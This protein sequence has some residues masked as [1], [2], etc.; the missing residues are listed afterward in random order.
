MY[1]NRVQAHIK[2][3]QSKLKY[4]LAMLRCFFIDIFGRFYNFSFDG[5]DK[6]NFKLN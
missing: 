3:G 1:K 2:Y 5:D 6:V 4:I